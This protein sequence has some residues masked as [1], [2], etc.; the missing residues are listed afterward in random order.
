MTFDTLQ[1]T[2]EC[3][4]V[5]RLPRE[6]QKL[7]LLENLPEA[8]PYSNRADGCEWLRTVGQRE[9]LLR[10][11]KGKEG[12]GRDRK[13]KEGNR[14]E[15][16]GKERK[17]RE[18]KGKK[19]KERERKGKDG[20]GRE[21]K[22]KDGKGRKGRERKGE[23]DLE[24]SRRRMTVL[25]W[26]CLAIAHCHSMFPRRAEMTLLRVIPTMTFIKGSLVG[27]TSVLRTFRMSGKE[28][29]KERVSEGKS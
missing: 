27:E 5:P 14:M 2:S 11:R 1:N 15:R 18:R 29:V 3:H 28:L 13:G 8:R 10:E 17:E 22:G 23:V 20:K 12:N 4:E 7:A 9:P 19:G 21:R 26:A 6:T 24:I 16:T 25:K